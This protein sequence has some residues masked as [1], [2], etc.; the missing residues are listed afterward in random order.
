[1]RARRS[2]FGAA[3]AA[4]TLLAVACATG[5]KPEE[6]PGETVASYDQLV[7]ALRAKG[8]TVDPVGTISQPFFS[9]EGQV[10]SLNGEDVQVYEFSSEEEARTAADAISPDGGSIGTSMVSWISA[11][12]FYYA[13]KL[14]VL[15]VGE[16]PA[17]VA[18]LQDVLGPQI[19]GR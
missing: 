18:A 10:I 14:V 19:A 1:M 17:A 9:P 8:A 2:V 7:S 13:G 6:A 11:P 3:I 12:H 5:G 16:E 15:Y 4:M